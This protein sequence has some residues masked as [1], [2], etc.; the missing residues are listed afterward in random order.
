MQL[1]IS[2]TVG[3]CLKTHTPLPHSKDNNFLLSIYQA[4]SQSCR[5][6]WFIFQQIPVE[7]QG[8]EKKSEVKWV[9]K[10]KN[11]IFCEINVI[12]PGLYF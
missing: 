7:K 3:P 6:Y 4:G 11:L 8:W 9:Q 1:C 10:K 2:R 5:R 12:V